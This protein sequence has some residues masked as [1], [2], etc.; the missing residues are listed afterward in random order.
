MN[1]LLTPAEQSEVLEVL[2]YYVQESE[3]QYIKKPTK[4][5]RAHVTGMYNFLNRIGYTKCRPAWETTEDPR[6]MKLF[7]EDNK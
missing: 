6:Q 1:R 7:K 5:L 2:W 3:K 4:K